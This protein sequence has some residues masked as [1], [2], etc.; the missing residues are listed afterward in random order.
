MNKHK[1]YLRVSAPSFVHF[2][3]IDWPPRS[4][5]SRR[6][7]P[8]A[9]SFAELVP[10][11][12]LRGK[13]ALNAAAPADSH[14]EATNSAIASTKHLRNISIT[15]VALVRRARAQGTE[16]ALAKH[17]QLRTYK[18]LW[19][20]ARGFAEKCYRFPANCKS[21]TTFPESGKIGDG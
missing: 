2:V 7:P 21:C 16:T 6:G 10:N 3:A 17:T 13:G 19:R 15:L 14:G 11:T 20:T 9:C 12:C 18:D 1:I 4:L 8:T 5:S